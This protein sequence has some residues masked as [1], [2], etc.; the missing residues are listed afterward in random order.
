M[1]ALC[2]CFLQRNV[3]FLLFFD[4]NEGCSFLSANPPKCEEAPTPSFPPRHFLL[5]TQRT[6]HWVHTPLGVTQSLPPVDL[7]I[8]NMN[9]LPKLGAM[10]CQ[11]SGQLNNVSRNKPWAHPFDRSVNQIHSGSNLDQHS[12][13]ANSCVLFRKWSLFFTFE[14]TQTLMAGLFFSLENSFFPPF[15]SFLN[16]TKSHTKGK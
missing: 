9:R 16:P 15:L 1:L 3:Q 5:Q 7:L 2:C 13:A 11:N 6:E 12:D 10:L 8:G 4:F 14:G